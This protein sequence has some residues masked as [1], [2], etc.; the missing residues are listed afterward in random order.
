MFVLIFHFLGFTFIRVDA[1][2]LMKISWG[3]SL[4]PLFDRPKS[5]F[6][7][8]LTVIKKTAFGDKIGFFMASLTRNIDQTRRMYD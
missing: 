6:N 1:F 7:G 2:T 4:R 8:L 5:D 3:L